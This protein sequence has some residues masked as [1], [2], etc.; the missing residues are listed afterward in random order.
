MTRQLKATYPP[1]PLLHPLGPTADLLRHGQIKGVHVASQW[2]RQRVRCRCICLLQH[3]VPC[4]DDAGLRDGCVLWVGRHYN[5]QNPRASPL[6]HSRLSLGFIDSLTT[7][8]HVLYCT[9]PRRHVLLFY[10]CHACRAMPYRA[11]RLANTPCRA[12]TCEALCGMAW[13]RAYGMAVHRVAQ[14]NTLCTETTVISA[15][16]TAACSFNWAADLTSGTQ[17]MTTTIATGI[18]LISSSSTSTTY[19]DNVEVCPRLRCTFW[20]LWAVQ[21]PPPPHA[22][23]LSMHSWWPCASKSDLAFCSTAGQCLPRRTSLQAT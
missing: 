9:V 3:L 1:H 2:L 10:P 20:G 18:W 13:Y 11:M 6:Q 16:G 12:I 8:C 7:S 22:T 23:P 21:A 17:P 19:F 4:G 14:H 5:V 15:D